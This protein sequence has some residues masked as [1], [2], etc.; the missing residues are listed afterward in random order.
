MYNVY[1]TVQY[2]YYV[3]AMRREE[4]ENLNNFWLH[5]LWQQLL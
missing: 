3:C 5:I 4:E 2:E 1:S